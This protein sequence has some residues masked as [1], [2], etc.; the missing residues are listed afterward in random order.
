MLL[1]PNPARGRV[2]DLGSGSVAR[3]YLILLPAVFLLGIGVVHLNVPFGWDELD[4]VSLYLDRLGSTGIN[5]QVSQFLAV[6]G[7]NLWGI[8]P[9][10]A[11]LPTLCF[12][13]GIVVTGAWL[14]RRTKAYVTVAVLFLHLCFSGMASWYLHS[15][16][17][18]SGMLFACFLMF[19]L[20]WD[21]ANREDLTASWGRV[22]LF[23]AAFAVGIFSHTFTGLFLRAPLWIGCA[24]WWHEEGDFVGRAAAVFS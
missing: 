21:A 11:R 17:G 12:A 2:T 3:T 18:Y 14:A 6:R 5:H 13:L 23:Y 8:Y 7:M 22:L 1:G 16:R 15:F 19:S 24:L 10:A 9:W 4:F 20:L